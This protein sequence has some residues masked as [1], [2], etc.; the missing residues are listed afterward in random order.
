MKKTLCLILCLALIFSLGTAALAADTD[1]VRSAD[2][3]YRGISIIVNDTK[4]VPQDANGNPVEPFIMEGTTYLPVRAIAGALGLDVGWNGATNTVILTSG[5]PLNNGSGRALATN[6]TKRVDITF[7]GIRITLDGYT[8]EPT[9][10]AGE[11]VEPF[12]LGGT[13]YLPVRGIANA[14]G[15]EVEWDAATS[16]VRLTAAAGENQWVEEPFYVLTKMTETTVIGSDSWAEVT[17]YDYNSAGQAVSE[18]R[19]SPSGLDFSAAHYYSDTGMPLYTDYYA[20]SSRYSVYYTY[21][22]N[23]MLVREEQ[24]GDDPLTTVYTYNADGV[25]LKS[26]TLHND[27]SEFTLTV[28]LN[29][30]GLI[31]T[32]EYLWTGPYDWSSIT[33]SY[34][35]NENE[36]TTQRVTTYRGTADGPGEHSETTTYTYSSDFLIYEDTYD[37]STSRRTTYKYDSRGNKISETL[38]IDGEIYDVTDFVYDSNSNLIKSTYTAGSDYKVITTYEYKKLIPVW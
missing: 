29:R 19:T 13:T 37:G 10:A 8:L 18:K 26:R 31:E 33:Y 23:G 11:V 15:A 27:G 2:I 38:T 3:T 14:L 34:T 16:T 22:E 7:R 1:F 36:Q 12:I 24:T 21:G 25:L 6:A 35:Y 9:N 4:I 20:Y 5:A 30:R 17:V 32:E 28:D